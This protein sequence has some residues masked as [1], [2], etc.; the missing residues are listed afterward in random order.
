MAEIERRRIRVTG[1]VQG[2]G[3]R[4]YTL[5]AARRHGVTGFVRNEVDGSV[6][7]EAQGEAGVLDLFES[8]V[9]RGPSYSRVDELDSEVLG[10]VDKR[11]RGFEIR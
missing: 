2:V 7:C 4:Y 10:N 8:D 6:L 11:E 5:M 1:R 9:Q 3:F